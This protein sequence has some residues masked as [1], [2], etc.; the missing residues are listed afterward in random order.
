MVFPSLSSHRNNTR[1]PMMSKVLWSTARRPQS[2]AVP[3]AE[4]LGLRSFFR[5]PVFASVG[6]HLSV[7]SRMTTDPGRLPTGPPSISLGLACFCLNQKRYRKQTSSKGRRAKQPSSVIDRISD[8]LMRTPHRISDWS[9]DSNR[10]FGSVRRSYSR[11]S[12]CRSS[13]L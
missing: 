8:S 12:V 9:V 3:P 7:R 4:P 13:L 5:Q 6:S 10:S 1:P 11:N 2:I